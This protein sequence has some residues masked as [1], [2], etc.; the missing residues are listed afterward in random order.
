MSGGKQ[1][2]AKLIDLPTYYDPWIL[3][4]VIL[5]DSISQGSANLP[6]K[7]RRGTMLDFAGQEVSTQPLDSL[8]AAQTL[9]E[10][11][12]KLTDVPIKLY[13]Q[14][15]VAGQSCLQALIANPCW[16]EQLVFIPSHWEN[17]SGTNTLRISSRNVEF[18]GLS[19]DTSSDLWL[20]WKYL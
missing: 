8:I 19:H 9:P 15:Q 5:E 7:G 13:W 16:S 3:K 1:T 10:T 2:E 20:I 18:T 4:Y 11:I 12:C 14:K 17:P 6:A